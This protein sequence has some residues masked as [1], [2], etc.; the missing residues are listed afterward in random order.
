[1]FEYSEILAQLSAAGSATI[2]NGFRRKVTSMASCCA[3]TSDVIVTIPLY[4]PG[5]GTAAA[6]API[7]RGVT[8]L[9]EM[10]PENGDTESHPP[11]EVAVA[12]NS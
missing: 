3:V 10:V 5:P 2:A 4:V 1:M 11:A 6:F 9:A 7:M 12:V 8:G